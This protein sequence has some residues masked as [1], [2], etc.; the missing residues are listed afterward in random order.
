MSRGSSHVVWLSGAI[1]LSNSSNS[2]PSIRSH[3]TRTTPDDIRQKDPINMKVLSFRILCIK[4][5]P[6]RKGISYPDS[7]EIIVQPE[8]Y[9]CVIIIMIRAYMHNTIINFSSE[10]RSDQVSDKDSSQKYCSIYKKHH[11]SLHL[12]SS[13]N[14]MQ[15]LP[16]SVSQAAACSQE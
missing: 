2:L 10:K 13:E 8:R 14:N 16:P 11:I 1:F 7:L 9:L 4:F 15:N 12:S 5:K 3:R 6:E